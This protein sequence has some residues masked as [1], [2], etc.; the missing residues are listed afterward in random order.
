MPSHS[1]PQLA[2]KSP[3]LARGLCSWVE[4]ELHRQTSIWQLA[5]T[6]G[7]RSECLGAGRAAKGDRDFLGGQR[8]PRRVADLL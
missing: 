3:A 5:Q 2:G 8:L 1:L 4:A 6:R 7:R